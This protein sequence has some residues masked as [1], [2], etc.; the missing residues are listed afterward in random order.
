[1]FYTLCI[2]ISD[3]YYTN[4]LDPH[5]LVSYRSCT[6]ML[7]WSVFF[8]LF[9]IVLHS[10]FIY[11]SQ[12]NVEMHLW[13]GGMY[14]NHIIANCMQSVLVKEFRKS[15]NNWQRYGQK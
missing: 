7:V 8:F 6:A 12:G 5:S 4:H 2:A 9:I 15:V 10:Y 11:I 1:M 13:C 3:L 14:N